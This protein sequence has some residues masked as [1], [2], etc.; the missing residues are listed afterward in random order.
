MCPHICQAQVPIL[1]QLLPF[2]TATG[3]FE[4]P[5]RHHV[6]FAYRTARR[7]SDVPDPDSQPAIRALTPPHTSTGPATD[8]P[9]AVGATPDA[10]QVHVVSAGATDHAG[11]NR[12]YASSPTTAS[13][14]TCSMTTIS[15]L[16]SC[17]VMAT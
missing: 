16:E 17:A 12:D 3:A 4:H 10:N 5:Y 1:P 13:S 7:A 15:S 14:S 2:T 8:V 9:P 11:S 6:T